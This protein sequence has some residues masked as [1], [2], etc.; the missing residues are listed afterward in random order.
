MDDSAPTTDG[1]RSCRVLY[2]DADDD[3]SA[4]LERADE[5]LDV[6]TVET[7]AEARHRLDRTPVDCLLV[8]RRVP[9]DGPV[10]LVRRVR[11]T[12]PDLPVVLYTDRGSEALAGDA[13]AAG[14]SDY[15]PRD[16]D[17]GVDHLGSR[18]RDAVEEHRAERRARRDAARVSEMQARISDAFYAVDD[19]WRVTYW[20]EQMAARTGVDAAEVVG[21]VVW[22]HFPDLEGSTLHDRYREAVETQEPVTFETYLDALGYWVEVRAYPSEDG[23]SVFSR[24][25]SDRVE[26][27]R[28]LERERRRFEAVFT[29]TAD[30]MVLTDGERVVT[31]VNPAAERLFGYDAEALVGSDVERLYADGVAYD[32]AVERVAERDADPVVARYRR[33]DGTTFEGETAWTPLR[34]AADDPAALGVIRDVSDRIERE[35]DLLG[36][37]VFLR[38]FTE[39]TTDET[40]AFDEQLRRLLTLCARRFGLEVGVFGVLDDGT[41]RVRTAVSPDDYVAEGDEH[42]LSGTVCA[43]V[44]ERG[45]VVA[46]VDGDGPSDCHPAYPD[47][48]VEAYLGAPVV[49]D[50]EVYGTLG[51]SSP[52]PRSEQIPAYERTLV[53]LLAQWVGRELARKRSK[54]RER[55]SRRRLREIIDLLPQFVFAKD[56]TGEYLLANE[57]IAT[58][59]GTTPRE[60]EGS[61]DAD[62]VGDEAEI[63]RFRADDR[64]V[65]DS[66]ESRHIPEER[67]T[68]AAGETRLLETRK[69]PFDDGGDDAVLGVATDVTRLKERE[70]ALERLYTTA[71]DLMTGHG[72]T[73][74]CR[75]AVET[76]EELGFD[77]SGVHLFDGEALSPVA[78]TD[79]AAAAFGRHPPRYAD[80]SSVVWEAFE[81]GE[82]VV[83]E[84]ATTAEERLPDDTVAQSALLLPLGDHG[85]FVTSS[86]EA[87][88]FDDADYY[89]ARLLAAAT[90]TALDRVERE[91][92]LRDRERELAERNERLD[93]FASVVAHDLRNPLAVATGMVQ[94]ARETDDAA[95]LDRAS[96]ALD[97]MDRLVD[98]LLSLARAGDGLDDPEPVSL[99]EA[100]R[101]AWASVETRDATLVVEGGDAS[102]RADESRLVQLL[103]NLF[104]NAVEHGGTGDRLDA[105]DDAERGSSGGHQPS[106]DDV[107][108]ASTGVTVRVGTV[109]DG[110]FVED[111]GTGIPA[112][113]RRRVLERGFTTDPTGTGFGLSIVADVADAHGWTTSVTEAAS[114]GA[115]FEFRDSD[116]GPGAA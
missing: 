111:D 69:I 18:L 14:V 49:V 9:D 115:R 58:A 37:S 29:D 71:R 97:R 17:H 13:V 83:I 96:A 112:A 5:G 15:V 66:G 80:E 46:F 57:A 62:F 89:F 8:G 95:S 43:A 26:R 75:C 94:L 38:R 114:G 101:G 33:R 28:E 35:D 93:E 39:V 31:D 98:D 74:A 42:P 103:E 63:T 51:F 107:D 54:R 34:A 55:E 11:E 68:T 99:G 19:E 79:G 36:R 91:D 77:V 102:V 84:D 105:G 88:D 25:V 78:W 21:D 52:R 59:Y 70:R 12:D 27:E 32:H 30:A 40:A 56:E 65:I 86:P 16:G 61:R 72:V 50:G 81:S 22:D 1:E 116:G 47:A 109:E 76:A 23:L 92:E 4:R 53:R 104:R 100:A 67:L 48:A 113:D 82:S 24:D 7:G 6:R 20:N 41:Y 64:A 2:V 44:A 106:D 45:D 10:S 85:V 60:M 3:L 73:S 87:S 90:E 108:R 110:F